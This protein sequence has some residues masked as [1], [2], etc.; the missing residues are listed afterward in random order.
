MADRYIRNNAGTLTETEATAASTGVAQAGDVVALDGNG[1]LDTSLMPTGIAADVSVVPASETLT[2]GDI[3]NIWDDAGTGKARK[4]DAS[5]AGK[6]AHGFVLAA[7]ITGQDATVYFEG[8]NNQVTG[9]SIGPSFLSATT[10]GLTTGTAP[11]GAGEI[12]QRVGITTAATSMNFEA[13]QPI[14]LA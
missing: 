3:V 7:V 1:K 11:S 12:V 2:A 8:T 5:A 13:G 10:P 4:A 14:V 9:L 6:E